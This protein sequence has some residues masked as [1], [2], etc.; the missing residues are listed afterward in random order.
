MRKRQAVLMERLE[1]AGFSECQR[2]EF[3]A[4]VLAAHRRREIEAFERWQVETGLLVCTFC[5]RAMSDCRGG[6]K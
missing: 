1:A 5:G 6:V 2:A 4:R 3:A